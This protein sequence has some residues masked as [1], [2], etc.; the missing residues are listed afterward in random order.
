MCGIKE[1][2][3]MA[4]RREKNQWT[5]Q[6]YTRHFSGIQRVKTVLFYKSHSRR[7]V[8]CGLFMMARNTL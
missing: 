5:M 7:V 2:K 4:S 6:R 8:E 3:Q 1:V